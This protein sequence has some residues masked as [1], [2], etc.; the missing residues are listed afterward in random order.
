MS[1]LLPPIPGEESKTTPDE[2]MTEEMQSLLESV[3]DLESEN[4]SAEASGNFSQHPF[5]PPSLPTISSPTLDLLPVEDRPKTFCNGC[6][7][8]HWLRTESEIRV[9]CKE[10]YFWPDA[11]F[12]NC[13]GRFQ[14]PKD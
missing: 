11:L 10:M 3:P 1:D 6:P 9:Y 13:D 14:P 5:S 12:P 2:L 7:H 4:R 8:A